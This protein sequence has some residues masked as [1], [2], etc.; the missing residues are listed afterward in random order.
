MIIW[1]WILIAVIALIIIM[2]V[3]YY[4]RFVVLGNRI[5]NSLAQIDVQLKKR[6]DLIPNLLNTVKGYMKH[7]K[8]II[9][10]VT[11]ARTAM[12]SAT[13]LPAR[14][15][16]GAELQSALRSVFALS[17]NYPQLKANEN[18]IN[19][20]QELSSIEDRIAYARQFYNDAIVTYNNSVETF[21]GVMFA[22]MWG[23]KAKEQ[24]Q[25]KEEEKA[26][27]KVQF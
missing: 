2:F 15:Q 8:S 21:P 13:T 16:A 27:P 3:V 10:E 20:Q 9:S 1:L 12:L 26:V 7:E 22:R 17:E 4:N 5:E 23:K 24:L 6:S 25:I 19:L 11:K 18:F 14:A